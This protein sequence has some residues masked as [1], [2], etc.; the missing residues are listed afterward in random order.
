MI[1]VYGKNDC[2]EDTKSMIADLGLYVITGDMVWALLN[3]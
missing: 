3:W 1:P 2:F